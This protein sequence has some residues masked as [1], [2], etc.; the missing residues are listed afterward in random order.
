MTKEASLPCPS[1]HLLFPLPQ[2]SDSSA[3]PGRGEREWR[4]HTCFLITVTTPPSSLVR[5]SHMAPPTCK[6][7]LKCSPRPG[8]PF[9]PE[10]QHQPSHLSLPWHHH[11][12][13]PH[14]TSSTRA[15]SGTMVPCTLRSPGGGQAVGRTEIKFWLCILPGGWGWQIPSP[16]EPQFRI[17]NRHPAV[18]PEQLL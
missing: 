10:S 3:C 11:H 15:T 14:V 18:H 5:T 17:C 6:L 7:C 9:S 16:P 4:G 13:H 8:G 2:A 12:R 1:Q